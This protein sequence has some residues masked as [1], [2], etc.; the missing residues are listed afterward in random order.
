[1]EFPVNG[2]LQHGFTQN[3]EQKK[4]AEIDCQ[5]EIQDSKT[6]LVHVKSE[7]TGFNAMLNIFNPSVV[8][9][10]CKN[11]LKVEDFKFFL[12]SVLNFTKLGRNCASVLS[13]TAV[14]CCTRH[15]PGPFVMETFY[16][17]KQQHT[18]GRYLQ[19]D[20]KHKQKGQT[21]EC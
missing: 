10:I 11:L 6:S 4:I 19:T 15:T 16:S 1:M 9:K 20:L 14:Q 7:K 13:L 17:I 8:T 3:F 12:Y 2:S 18:A 5:C 21:H